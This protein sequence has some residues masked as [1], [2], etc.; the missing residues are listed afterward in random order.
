MSKQ[1]S[2][3]SKPNP[4]K[5]PFLNVPDE[6]DDGVRMPTPEEARRWNEWMAQRLKEDKE[7][8][9]A[10][11]A[12]ATSSQ[13]TG[14]QSADQLTAAQKAY[15]KAQTKEEK[16][17]ASTD[18]L[19][20]L[21]QEKIALETKESD[22][23]AKKIYVE[24][25]EEWFDSYKRKVSAL[26]TLSYDFEEFSDSWTK[27]NRKLSMALETDRETLFKDRSQILGRLDDI[28]RERRRINITGEVSS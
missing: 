12:K 5:P 10:H 25:Q 19:E 6:E 21:R 11:Y 2:A 24:S 15:A 27:H 17:Q 18:R 26:L 13:K 16:R 1:P 8:F 14:A 28:D 20:E 7:R 23:G 22:L 4:A 9:Q 3:S